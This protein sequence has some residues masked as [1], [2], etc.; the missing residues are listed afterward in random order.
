[1]QGD[2]PQFFFAAMRKMGTVPEVLKPVLVWA[3]ERLLSS[4]RWWGLVQRQNGVFDRCGR[5]RPGQRERNANPKRQRGCFVSRSVASRPVDVSVDRQFKEPESSRPA[6]NVGTKNPRWRFLKLRV[7]AVGARSVR[8]SRRN[9][10]VLRPQLVAAMNK[11]HRGDPA[12]AQGHAGLWP[13]PPWVRHL[14]ERRRALSGRPKRRIE[15][16][17]RFCRPYRA[18]MFRSDRNLGRRRLRRLCPR[19]P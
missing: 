2:S 1:M 9:V 10:L 7:F 17:P 15:L 3:F 14:H 6:A 4:W 19:L 8:L 13:A 16:S 11:P 12:I 18:L 5:T